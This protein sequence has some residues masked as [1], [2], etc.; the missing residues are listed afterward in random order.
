MR[1]LVVLIRSTILKLYS[2]N[3][4]H[5]AQWDQSYPLDICYNDL[6]GG[7]LYT[8]ASP[9]D[10]TG[11]NIVLKLSSITNA[12][13]ESPD[14]SAFTSPVDVCY[15]DLVCN[16]ASSCLDNQAE[17]V[18]L[19]SVTNAHLSKDSTYP[20]IICC[21]SA[22]AG[23]FLTN[24]HWKNMKGEIIDG[25]NVNVND[26]VTLYARTAE[27]IPVSF[28][29]YERDSAGINEIRVGSGAF[30]NSSN[31]SGDVTYTWRITDNDMIHSQSGQ[32]QFYFNVTGQGI[33]STSPDL[34]ANNTAGNV[35][36]SCV[37]QSPAANGIYFKDNSL[38]LVTNH[39]ADDPDSVVSITWKIVDADTNSVEGTVGGENAIYNLQATG[40]K[41]IRLNV[42]DESGASCYSETG[43]SV[44]RVPITGESTLTEVF[45]WID[46][47][48]RIKQ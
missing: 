16:F 3:N 12:H 7:K 8:G 22:F 47:Q 27:N 6:F 31:S 39:N 44:A 40:T 23:S 10:C 29:V 1:V 42:V 43:I 19:S 32:S 15:G 14:S 20:N 21:S 26:S 25:S 9:H 24:A 11:S 18:R 35:A 13:A 46:S 48:L 33:T 36:P 37:I 45:A 34:I 38:S 30:A 2:T 17:V 28:E 41:I 4:T 5:G